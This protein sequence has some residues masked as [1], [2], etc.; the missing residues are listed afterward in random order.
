MASTGV[1]MMAC[2]GLITPRTQHISSHLSTSHG[3]FSTFP[4]LLRDL[5]S[6]HSSV[7]ISLPREALPDHPQ[8]GPPSE[9]M[10]DQAQESWFCLVQCSAMG[11]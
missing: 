10:D 8:Q 11:R 2:H 3:L 5:E 1:A 9:P 7:K 6:L 4:L